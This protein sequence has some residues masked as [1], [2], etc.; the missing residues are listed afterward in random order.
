MEEVTEDMESGAFL[1]DCTK[2]DR[3]GA[4]QQDGLQ[5]CVAAGC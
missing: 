2:V 4:M 1:E 3:T 5:N